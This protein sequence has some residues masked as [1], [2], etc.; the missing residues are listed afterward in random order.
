MYQRCKLVH[1]DLSEY[2]LLWHK[3]QVYVIDVS[4]SVETSHP[5]ALKLLRNDCTNINDYFS[6]IMSNSGGGGSCVNGDSGNEEQQ[7]QQQSLQ[8]LTT[9]QLF[10]FVTTPLS[11]TSTS[12]DQGSEEDME[13]AFLNQLF[14]Q[15][16]EEQTRLAQESEQV[17]REHVH[18]EQVEEAVFMS[19]YLPR[20]LKQVGEYE[21]AQ[22]EEGQ[23]E[24]SYA[25]AVTA[26]TSNAPELGVV[27]ST[28]NHDQRH[29]QGTS[30]KKKIQAQQKDSVVVAAATSKLARA[31]VNGNQLTT[32]TLTP[33]EPFV[34]AAADQTL[35]DAATDGEGQPE[36]V[37]NAG[38]EESS[39]SDD[40][41][42][43]DS[44]SE[45]DGDDEPFMKVARTP[46]QLIVV[47]FSFNVAVDML[48]AAKDQL[49]TPLWSWG[50][51]EAIYIE[52]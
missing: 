37:E 38:G 13:M 14:Q 12:T 41:M 7:Q 45:L 50:D 34:E 15:V 3:S 9:R 8:V 52:N 40:E 19:Q 30:H 51:L 32:P 36:K 49:I 2:N 44:E 4:Q 5:M 18:K 17:R 29:G 11:N 21:M 39:S 42:S 35:A 47:R 6:K 25:K 26:L 27:A 28:A 46:D 22:M 16:A 31:D 20:S 10:E 1:G 24:E 23:A 33:S 48:M 43:V